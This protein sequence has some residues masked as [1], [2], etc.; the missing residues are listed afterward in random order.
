M[1]LRSPLP[2]IEIAQARGDL[3][4]D[5]PAV[6]SAH[7]VLARFW[8]RCGTGEWVPPTKSATPRSVMR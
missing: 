3:R 6:A 1:H 4:K 5:V 2:Q 7:F 8:E